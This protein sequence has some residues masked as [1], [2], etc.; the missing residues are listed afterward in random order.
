MYICVYGASSTS[1]DR[2]FIEAS[3]ELG[4]RIARRGHGVVF[5]AGARGVM[6]AVAR[7]TSEYN[8]EII[9]V[10]PHFFNRD[11]IIYQSCSELIRTDTMRE[12]KQIMEDRSDAFIVM[13]GGIGTLEEFFEILTLKQLNR[14]NKAIVVFNIDG[15]YDH[16][17]RMIDGIVEK[18]FMP[19]DNRH[20]YQ[21]FTDIDEMLDYIENYVPQ[22]TGTPKY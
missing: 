10:V 18:S 2:K 6:G 9:G 11:E 19:S 5:G 8:G 3:E 21:S 14:H 22:D 17:E 12:R 4:R 20:L 15:F 7:G 1:I 13:P 16:M